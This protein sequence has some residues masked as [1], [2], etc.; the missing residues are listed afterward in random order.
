MTRA[1]RAL[2][3]AGVVLGGLAPVTGIARAAET[4]AADAPAAAAAQANTVE[5]FFYRRGRLPLWTSYFSVDGKKVAA[6]SPARCTYATA[7]FPAGPH[8]V[9]H[10]WW[11]ATS[12]MQ[13]LH[14]TWAPNETRYYRVDYVPSVVSNL[15]E[16]TPTAAKAELSDCRRVP[17]MNAGPGGAGADPAATPAGAKGGG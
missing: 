8:A 13:T 17:S 3:V 9:Q 6:L 5:V 1:M 16:I 10:A 12:P 2:A 15:A 7:T 14:A 4:P 11:P